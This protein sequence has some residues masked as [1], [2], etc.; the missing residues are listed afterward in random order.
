VEVLQA[1]ADDY[2][3]KPIYPEE[4]MARVQTGMRLITLEKSYIQVQHQLIN[5]RNKLKIIYDAIQEEIVAIDT[6][7]KI[8]SLNQS[9]LKWV[10]ANCNEV[11][12]NNF[13][14]F[15]DAH[16]ANAIQQTFEN[17]QKQTFLITM[18]VR[19]RSKED[20][21]VAVLPIPDTAGQVSMVIVVMKD[22]TEDRRHAQE[23]LALNER[24]VKSAVQLEVKNKKL[25]KTL[26]QLEE[27]QAHMVQSEKMA[28]IG[29]LAAGVA[30]E[31]NN[32]TGFVSSNLKT[33]ADYKADLS[34]L[35]EKYQALRGKLTASDAERSQ[36]P[37]VGALVKE[38]VS[39]EQEIDIDFIL[40][41]MTALIGDCRE[42]TERIKKIVMDL[43]D[44]AHPGNDQLQLV[45][46]NA[47]LESTLNVVHNEIKYKAEVHRSFGDIPAV[48]GY[49]Q[50]LNQVFMNILVNAAQAIESEGVI[51]IVTREDNGF[52]ENLS[53]IF[54]PFFTTKEVGKGTG[55]G[56][57]IAYNIIHKH[58]GTI[59]VHSTVGKGT[60]FTILIPIEPPDSETLLSQT[61]SV[62]SE[63][64]TCTPDEPGVAPH[65]RDGMN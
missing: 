16:L 53:K 65:L 3:P 44:F 49:T 62:T 37:G 59:Q 60:C 19:G 30:H 22:V 29:Q 63:P 32:P 11:V 36:S 58:H 20:R 15:F 51:S 47:G 5:S 28:S 64:C 45:D 26:K 25:E 35:I 55:L 61:K 23:I 33:L 21:Q 46:I 56:M 27:T 41:D 12:G 10:G 24:L 52:V 42:G 38:I 54:D 8:I 57:H 17:G 6:D 14:D 4:L 50:Q 2:I 43:K 9:C 48:L 1:G 31:I 34:A 40:S 13:R 7:F 18:S 39:F